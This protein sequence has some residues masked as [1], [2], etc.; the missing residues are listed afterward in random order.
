[1]IEAIGAEI[2]CRHG[3]HVLALD[4]EVA[5]EKPG[6]NRGR[7]RANGEQVCVGERE[8]VCVNRARFLSLGKRFERLDAVL[9]DLDWGAWG[10]D[11]QNLGQLVGENRA[12]DGSRDRAADEL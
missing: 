7:T 6:E 3:G 4:A 11:R 9:Q 2:L 10:V 12:C 8:A 1:M 5:H